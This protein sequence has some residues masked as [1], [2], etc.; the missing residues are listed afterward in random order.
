MK[1]TTT[2]YTLSDP[3]S[4]EIRYVG[5]SINAEAR[6]G[7]HL[8]DKSETH[9]ARWIR[10]LK[11]NGVS[12]VM[13]IVEIVED[14]DWQEAERFW[15]E[16]FRVMGFKLTNLDSGGIGGKRA[17]LETRK[18]LSIA[19]K[20]LVRSEQNRINSSL[21]AKGKKKSKEHIANM[22]AALKG[23]VFSPDWAKKLGAAHLGVPKSPE[24]RLKMSLSMRGKNAG[25]K[26]SEEA[27]LKMSNSQKLRWSKIKNLPAI[28][29]AAPGA[30]E[31][32]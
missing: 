20:G 12:P 23:R 19:L 14:K 15:I 2:I 10:R 6:L 11:A 27:R 25:K 1:L 4:G 3:I 8:R 28:T 26:A 9:K 24:Q 30:D 16:S 18:K 17:S 21:A 5:K 29:K 7:R 31:E 22:S 13:D 32:T